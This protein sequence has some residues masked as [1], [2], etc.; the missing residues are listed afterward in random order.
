M[1]YSVARDDIAHRVSTYCQK[2]DSAYV[3][4]KQLSSINKLLTSLDQKEEQ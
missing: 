2:E 3:K 1:D 4:Y